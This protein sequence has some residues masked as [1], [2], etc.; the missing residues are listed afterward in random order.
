[1]KLWRDLKLLALGAGLLA[2]DGCRPKDDWG[3]TDTLV[4]FYAAV[5]AVEPACGEFGS[6]VF[7]VSKAYGNRPPWDGILPDDHVRTVAGQYGGRAYG[8]LVRIE[9]REPNRPNSDRDSYL[10]VGV[11][12]C[13][14]LSPRRG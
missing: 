6:V 4:G 12:A 8:H 9:F 3:Q 11:G 7:A 5:V 14:Q 13:V 10:R 1:M 2:L